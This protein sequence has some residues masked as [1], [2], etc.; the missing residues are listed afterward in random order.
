MAWKRL[1][2]LWAV[3]GWVVF[4]VVP[5]L[6]EEAFNNLVHSLHDPF[7]PD[8]VFPMDPRGWDWLTWMEDLGPLIGFGFLAGATAGLPDSPPD[9]RGRIRRLLSRRTI[10]VA[11]GPWTG[12]IIPA[13]LFATASLLVYYVLPDRVTEQVRISAQ[14]LVTALQPWQ[15]LW[16]AWA[17]D[18][19][20]TSEALS[21]IGVSLLV[22]AFCYP[23]LIFAYA[24]VRRARRLGMAWRC[25]GQGLAVAAA[26]VGSLF[27]SFWAVTEFWRGYFF[28]PRIIPVL[29]VASSLMV[30]EGCAPT[31]TYG[32]VRRR[33]LFHGMLLAWT[34]GL[35]LLWRWWARRRP[36]G[37]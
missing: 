13:A 22:G 8:G 3:V 35:A 27:A 20:A 12:M 4:P 14:R 18:H 29:L 32:E 2:A 11:A 15:P 16:E 37:G 31:I 34:I 30:M 10:W 23:W 25:V 24:A 1:G 19:P 28:D 17:T 6:L 36:R 21:G 9:G 7:L 26:Y 33:E 5:G